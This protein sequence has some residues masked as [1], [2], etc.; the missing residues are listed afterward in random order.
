MGEMSESEGVLISNVLASKELAS[1]LTF[2]Y[3]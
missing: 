1:C 2:E 3:N